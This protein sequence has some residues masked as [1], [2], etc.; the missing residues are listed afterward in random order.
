MFRY[1]RRPQRSR[2]TRLA[3]SSRA[4][5][6]APW[7]GGSNT[8]ASNRFSSAATSGLRNRSR[9]SGSIGFRPEAVSAARLSAAMA[10][11]SSSAANTRAFAASRSANGPTPQNRSATVFGAGA[12]SEHEPRQHGF[13][14]RRRLQKRRRRQ[15]HGRC[16]HAQGRRAG[17][18]RSIRRGASAARDSVR[19]RCG[20]A[21]SSTESSAAPEPRTSISRPASVAVTAMSSGFSVGTERL[22]DRPRG[23]PAR[24]RGFSPAPDSGRWR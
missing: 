13:A 11:S 1:C 15:R 19:R 12:C 2:G 23:R 5:A 21:P 20:R 17:A 22:G 4:C 24:R 18:A 10:A 6:C 8:T 9:A 3:A 16:A 7:R 14:F